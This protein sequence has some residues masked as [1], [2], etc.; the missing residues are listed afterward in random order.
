[1][2]QTLLGTVTLL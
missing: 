2:G 1:M